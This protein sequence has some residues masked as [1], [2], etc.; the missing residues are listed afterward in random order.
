MLEPHVTHSPLCKE[1][2]D[3]AHAKSALEYIAKTLYERIKPSR[4]MQ[5]RINLILY[6]GEYAERI[7]I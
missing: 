4:R 3:N 1:R 2:N 7:I 5:L 6:Y